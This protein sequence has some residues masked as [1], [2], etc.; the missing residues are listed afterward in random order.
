MSG[1]IVDNF[2]GGG[3]A[4]PNTVDQV[5]AALALVAWPPAYAAPARQSASAGSKLVDLGLDSLD[6]QSLACEL[7]DA[8]GITIPDDDPAEWE[9][10][11]DVA[12]TIERLR[13]RHG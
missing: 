6:R 10:V 8:L 5:L 7:E 13:G 4:S 12:T 2:A 9:T 11:A 1:L 3:G